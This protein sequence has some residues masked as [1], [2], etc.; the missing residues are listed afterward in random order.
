MVSVC[1]EQ[2]QCLGGSLN[3]NVILK[4]I[5]TV[6]NILF[7]LLSQGYYLASLLCVSALL[8]ASTADPG[9]LAQDPKIPLAGEK[10]NPDLDTQA[11][12]IVLRSI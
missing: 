9:K 5:I 10:K 11:M 6:Q 8:R 4:Y 2:F 12:Q 3:Q 1:F 7:V